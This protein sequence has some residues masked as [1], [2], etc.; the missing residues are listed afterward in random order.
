MPLIPDVHE[1]TGREIGTV[2][3]VTDAA[4]AVGIVFSGVDVALEDASVSSVKQ[5]PPKHTPASLFDVHA[6]P[7]GSNAPR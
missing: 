4:A 2:L 3:V 5:T 7:S 6:V 1:E